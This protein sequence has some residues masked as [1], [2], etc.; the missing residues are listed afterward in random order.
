MAVIGIVAAVSASD[1]HDILPEEG[2]SQAVQEEALVDDTFLRQLQRRRDFQNKQLQTPASVRCSVHPA[3]CLSP[4]HKHWPA[5]PAHF[6]DRRTSSGQYILSVTGPYGPPRYMS[7]TRFQ[8][9]LARTMTI[10]S[11]YVSRGRPSHISAV[12]AQPF[13]YSETPACR[14]HWS[15]VRVGHVNQTH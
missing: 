11:M 3:L 1:E 7:A 15:R 4:R 5:S 8:I 13:C 6:S 9:V 10:D 12:F 2:W 14:E